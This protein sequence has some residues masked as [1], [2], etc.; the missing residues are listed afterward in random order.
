MGE[1]DVYIIFDLISGVNGG[2]RINI[3]LLNS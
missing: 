2:F 3:A 1:S